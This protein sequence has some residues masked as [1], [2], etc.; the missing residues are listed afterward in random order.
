M[1]FK[2][3]DRI[4][5]FKGNHSANEKFVGC[6]ATVMRVEREYDDDRLALVWDH[7]CVENRLYPTEPCWSAINC[8]SAEVPY[9]PTQM[10][11][12]EDD[13]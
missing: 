2:V 9:D 1:T 3:G 6:T 10:G 12:R 7:D 13:I 8:R 4:E 5:Y 11:D